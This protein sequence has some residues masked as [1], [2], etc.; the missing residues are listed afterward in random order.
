MK[1]SNLKYLHIAIIIIGT[2]LIGLAVFHTNLWF[3]ESYSVALAKSSF[4]EIWQKGASDVHPVFY[5]ICLHILNL[6]FGNNIIVYRLFSVLA[7]SSLAVLGYTHIR[8]EFGAKAGILFS[9]LVLFLP[10]MAQYAGEIRM[11]PL[12]MLLGT[13][14][15]IYAYRIYKGQIHKATYIIFG[16][17]SLLVS[18]THYYGLMLA[19]IINL[20]LFIYLCKNIKTRKQD[21]IKFTITAVIQ[22]IAY[23]PW[24]ICFIKQ[25][26]GVSGGF[27]ATLTFPKSIYEML[28]MQY[29]GNFEIEPIILTTVFYAYIAYLISNTKKEERKPANWCFYIYIAIIVIAYII[30][31]ILGSVILVE[32]YLLVLTGLLIF[33]ISFFMANDKSKKRVI[34]ICAV[35]SVIS[36]LSNNIAIKENYNLENNSWKEYIQSNLQEGDIFIYTNAIN[37]A[38][39]ATELSS[40]IEVKTYYYNKPQWPIQESYKVYEPYMII[41]DTLEEILDNYKGRVWL[42]EPFDEYDLRD[43]INEK[44]NAVQI[45]ERKFWRPYKNYTFTIELLEV[46]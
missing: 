19:G 21:L 6:I 22:V 1:K 30:S 28:T 8:K 10:T 31:R 35:I 46:K 37:G 42:I 20:L 27:W 7:T 2:I 41:T 13:V 15:A 34:S 39:V 17:S 38:V 33:A 25:V 9:F 3:D 36:I 23:I 32:R 18:Y 45:D 44:Y 40:S 4:A 29:Q 43:E 5:Y 14:M 12:A 24:L 16:L 11:Y 26:Q